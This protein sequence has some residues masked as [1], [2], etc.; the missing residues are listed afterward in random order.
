MHD[1]LEAQ[2]PAVEVDRGVDVIDDVA[3]AYS[4]HRITSLV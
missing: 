4:G 2:L 1:L 3:D